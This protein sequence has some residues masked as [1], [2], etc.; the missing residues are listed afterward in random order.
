MENG[1][2]FKLQIHEIQITK[3]TTIHNHSG[4]TI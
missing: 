1:E 3:R 4:T 2:T